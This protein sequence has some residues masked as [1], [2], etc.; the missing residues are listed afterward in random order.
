MSTVTI[1]VDLAKNVFEVAVAARS[2][3]ISERRRLSRS[4]FERFW[5]GRAP[6]RVVMEACSTAHF[7]GRFLAARGFDVVLLPPH[8]V[9]PYRRRNKTDR[10]DCEAILEAARCSG[11]HPVAVK[12]E[13]Q[14]AL[15]ALHRARSQWVATR[16]ARINHMRGLLREFGI[17]A[18]AGPNRFM[19]ELHSLLELKQERLPVHVR[20]VLF[21]LWDEARDL[22]R[23]IEDMDRELALV[24]KQEPVARA[25]CGISGIGVLTATALFATVGNVHSF[26]DGRRLACWLGLT[27][28]EFSSG[29]KRRLGRISKQ[30]DPYVRTLLIHGARAALNG[31]R[32]LD[33]AHKP[34][35]Q[36]QRWALR[37][38]SETHPNQAVVALANKLARIAWA[39]WRHERD[40]DGNHVRRVAA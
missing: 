4:Q 30:G 17:I 15:L 6:C 12:S 3:R 21:S 36:L 28:R 2:G 27:P 37:R 11:I 32:R 25:L 19:R 39:V 16:T 40:F 38:A 24:A 5:S 35:T 20:R 23:R 26:P 34:L 14:Q 7:W 1:A 13:D 9:K 29:A 8:Y 18:P 33:K 10:A 22:E 31:A